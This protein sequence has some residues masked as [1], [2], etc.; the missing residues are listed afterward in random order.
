MRLTC[1]SHTLWDASSFTFRPRVYSISVELSAAGAGTAERR[2]S[3][4]YALWEH[5]ELHEHW[6]DRPLS[7]RNRARKHM[8]VRFVWDI[9]PSLQGF[10][11]SGPPRKLALYQAESDKHE[12]MMY[13]QFERRVFTVGQGRGRS[14]SLTKRQRT[15]KGADAGVSTHVRVQRQATECSGNSRRTPSDSA[16][17][18][19]DSSGHDATNFDEPDRRTDTGSDRHKLGRGRK[20][21]K[22]DRPQTNALKMYSYQCLS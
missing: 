21:L 2:R 12:M 4:T 1:D 17:N 13:S 18:I 3:R 8:C 5:E 6:H 15:P 20:R 10:S 11:H 19:T 14:A 9:F 16:H 22:S 7:L